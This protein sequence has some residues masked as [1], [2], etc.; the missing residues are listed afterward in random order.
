M[1]DSPEKQPVRCWPKEALRIEVE[2]R[3]IYMTC[4]V[5]ISYARVSDVFQIEN[6]IETCTLTIK[7]NDQ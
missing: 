4:S 2:S 7:W 1:V 3:S 5:P 6:V